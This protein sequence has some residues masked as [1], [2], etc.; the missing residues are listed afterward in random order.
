[1]V[2]A[3]GPAI[4]PLSVGRFIALANGDPTVFA[5][6]A[7]RLGVGLLEPRNNQSGLRLEL[8]MGHV[9]IGKRKKNWF[10]RGNDRDWDVI[11]SGARVRGVDPAVIR[12][13]VRI[14]GALH[15]RHRVV[16]AGGLTDPEH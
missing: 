1:M 8:A 3:E 2:G 13:P 12:R 11:L 5:N 4:F 14:P 15:V 6:G 9:V 16:A 10:L 7:A